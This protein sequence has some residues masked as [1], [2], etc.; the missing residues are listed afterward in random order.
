MAVI[1]SNG[2]TD[3]HT[4]SG[5]YRVESYNLSAFN[6]TSLSLASTRTISLTYANAGNAQGIVI[7]LGGSSTFTKDVTVTLKESGTIR[8]SKTLTAS[9]ICNST[10][11]SGFWI[12]PFTFTTPYAVTTAGGVWTLEITQGAGTGDWTILTSNGT[13][14][15]YAAWCDNA[16][17]F[18]NNDTVIC[19]DIVTVSQTCTIKGTLG[20]GDTANAVAVWVCKSDSPPTATNNV[21]KFQI[22]PAAT[23][24]LS[25]D[26][27]ITLGAHS[28]WQAGTQASPIPASKALTYDQIPLTVG[29]AHGI[30]SIGPFSSLRSSYFFF[31]E[32]PANRQY[33]LTAQANT[34]A[35]SFSVA[36]TT[37]ISNGDVFFINNMAATSN[38]TVTYYTVT[39]TTATTVSVT[40]TIA[41]SN[42]IAGATA[43]RVNGFGINFVRT[44]TTGAQ[45]FSF[46]VPSNFYM[47]GVSMY[48]TNQAT[49][50]SFN[51]NYAATSQSLELNASY[52]SQWVIENCVRGTTSSV[53][54]A[55]G[56]SPYDGIR[57]EG[58]HGFGSTTT[59]SGF[60]QSDAWTA[61][62]YVIKNNFNGLQYNGYMLPGNTGYIVW[63]IED[64]YFEALSI[65]VL[66]GKNSTIK[67]NYIR[68]GSSGGWQWYL[69]NFINCTEWSGNTWDGTPTSLRFQQSVINLTM[70]N[71]LGLNS[72]GTTSHI[73]PD[74]GCNLI[75]VVMEKPNFVPIIS[76]TN[77]LV[78]IEGTRLA[79]T[80]SNS[81]NN[82]DMSWTRTGEIVRT[83]TSLADTTVRSAG[84]FAMRFMPISSTQLLKWEQTIPIGD[85]STKTMTIT[86][87]VYINNAAYYAGTHTKPTLSVNYDNGTTLSSVATGATG[88]QQLAV[89]FTPATSYGQVT[90]KVTGA[91]D[92][93][94]TNRYF[95]VDDVNVAYPA[96]YQVDL[97]SLDL[98]AAGLPVAPT[99]ATMPSITGVWDE[100]LSAHTITG[101]AGKTLNDAADSAELA[102]VS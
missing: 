10:D 97:G 83:G 18:S 20:T 28:G 94:G 8:A 31:G 64:N 17:T 70:R 95:Y 19:K 37:G 86:C 76:T 38:T 9:T 77:Q 47:S 72:P 39:G 66:R 102:S 91:T 75:N 22:Q 92:A 62:T 84:G 29:T 55:I 51:F 4:V 56:Y 12:T 2:N 73:Y 96:G 24:T 21:A 53:F 1:I 68:G 98:W 52:R 6:S 59:M 26:G 78:V 32:V 5:H 79:I 67:N 88:W 60:T 57:I 100:P 63:D 45:T 80:N 40:P 33:T 71:E 46:G 48:V 87:W 50:N 44:N 23:M 101:S 30:K 7:A 89:T 81:V 35:S 42:R 41:T 93:T 14:P 11:P 61:G 15:F 16:V 90:V 49:N 25:I 27:L 34:G 13:A 69:E 65:G 85:I 99:I 82:A 43:Y 58:C 36:S 74:A 3:L 54:L